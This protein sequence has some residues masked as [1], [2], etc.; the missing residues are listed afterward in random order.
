MVKLQINAANGSLVNTGLETRAVIQIAH[1]EAQSCCDIPC[2]NCDTGE[3]P[4]T[5]T[6]T[7]S[8]NFPNTAV[9]SLIDLVFAASFGS[10]ATAH[11]NG[12]G[13]EP[14]EV[15]L[16][17]G[18]ITSVTVANPGSGY[19]VLGRVAPTFTLDSVQRIV[20]GSYDATPGTGFAGTFTL[21]E[22]LDAI[23]NKRW[24][25]TG[26]TISNGGS[27]YGGGTQ[28]PG[29]EGN[30]VAF[31]LATAGDTDSRYGLI[32]GPYPQTSA[33]AL[34]AVTINAVD[35][36]D[37][38]SGYTNG[39]SIVFGGQAGS[40][41]AGT[42]SVNGSGAI[43]GV[44]I[45]AGGTA[46]R[47]ATASVS[48]GSGAILRP[49]GVVSSVVVGQFESFFA[50]KED[51]DEAP[52]VATV[53]VTL[54][55]LRSSAISI[56][57]VGTG[58]T[59]TV[60][61]DD[62]PVS[63]QFGQIESVSV[64]SGGSG[65]FAWMDQ[66]TLCC[67]D[68][69]GGKSFVLKRNLNGPCQPCVFSHRMCGVG[70][71]ALVAF[72]YNG[73]DEYSTV[74]ITPSGSNICLTAFTADVLLTDCS[75]DEAV[76]VHVD[77][78][79]V[80]GPTATITFPGDAYDE[81]YFNPGGNQISCDICCKGDSLVPSELSATLTATNTGTPIWTNATC[82]QTTWDG[83]YVL[84]NVSNGNQ[85]AYSYVDE[86]IELVISI[87]VC[88]GQGV[89]SFYPTD[90]LWN[91]GAGASDQKG[92]LGFQVCDE[93][94]RKCKMSWG[95]TVKCGEGVQVFPSLTHYGGFRT[96]LNDQYVQ[97]F[98][99]ISAGYNPPE[100]WIGDLYGGI[101][102][103]S[104]SSQIGCADIC[105]EGPTCDL[106]GHSEQM[107]SAPFVSGFGYLAVWPLFTLDT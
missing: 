9:L 86:N 26:M 2:G 97:A 34:L 14:D 98:R 66:R 104:P 36:I 100:T 3:L 48:S 80:D 32:E 47:C 99:A 37:A 31:A 49:S 79:D 38:G 71:D 92:S 13:G 93:C 16:N 69:W 53:T 41:A 42:I 17:V 22:T 105:I 11:A 45:T 74:T 102:L 39:E 107:G 10:G 27:G 21:A 57:Q 85:L 7:L 12:S 103:D 62:D 20:L 54:E 95:L 60:N 55:Q 33:I 18:P 83:T 24:A 91:T 40:G 84:T 106:A 65:Y 61:I 87:G 77:D 94:H 6:V 68:F 73:P 43:T 8:N 67:N 63:P 59:F 82:P 19:A 23:G 76:L 88:A 52:N 51:E 46:Y 50:W 29:N 56:S 25:I 89:S 4:K 70:S 64:D 81:Y 58:A 35:I 72:T 96:A 101:A 44:T 15:P 75:D 1:S 30:D 5:C 28:G 78:S 90:N